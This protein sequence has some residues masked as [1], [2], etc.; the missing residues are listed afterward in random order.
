MCIPWKETRILLQM[1]Y[2]C[3]FAVFC[4]CCYWLI[5]FVCFSFCFLGPHLQHM[6]VPRLGVKSELQL[7]AYTTATATQD[8][9]SVCSL[10]HSSWQH[11]IPGPLRKAKDKTHILINTSWIPFHCATRGILCTI[12]SWLFLPSFFTSPFLISNCLN[13]SFPCMSSY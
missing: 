7:T 2:Y 13:L 5:F 8:W 11:W 3:L 9:S 6:E 10:H 4:C 1:L 12:F